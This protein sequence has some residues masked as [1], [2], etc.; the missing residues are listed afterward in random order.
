MPG[1]CLS[2]ILRF[3]PCPFHSKQGTF[4]FHTGWIYPKL[5]QDAGFLVT[6]RMTW[7]KHPFRFG[8]L[9]TFLCHDGIPG[10]WVDPSY[11]KTPDVWWLVSGLRP[12]EKNGGFFGEQKT[13]EKTREKKRVVS[14]S[15]QKKC[16]WQEPLK[17]LRRF[18]DWDPTWFLLQFLAFRKV[19]CFKSTTV[20]F[21]SP[22]VFM[23]RTLGDH[24]VP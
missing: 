12:E 2:S 17:Y 8:N 19:T 22:G 4:G 1:T 21:L 15:P 16:L 5:P 10:G 6:N 24:Q 7:M 13:R 18:N 20:C 14:S 9:Q 23:W 11:V 3:G